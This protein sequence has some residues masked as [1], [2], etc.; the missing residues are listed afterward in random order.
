MILA[1]FFTILV[2][3]GSI[4][5]L[6]TEVERYEKELDTIRVSYTQNNDTINS[7]TLRKEQEGVNIVSAPETDVPLEYEQAVI[8]GQNYLDYTSFSRQ[9]LYNHLLYEGYSADA[10]QYAVDRLFG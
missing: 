8:E 9:G 5:S 10:A 1:Y 3:L 6:N 7:D 2:G 4:S